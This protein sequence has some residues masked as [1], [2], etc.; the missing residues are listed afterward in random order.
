MQWQH[1]WIIFR[2]F[3]FLNLLHS[4]SLT[5]ISFPIK[6]LKTLLFLSVLLLAVNIMAESEERVQTQTYLK[7]KRRP[8]YSCPGCFRFCLRHP[9]GGQNSDDSDDSDSSS[10]DSSSSIYGIGSR[11][12]ASDSISVEAPVW[13]PGGICRRCVKKCLPKLCLKERPSY[14]HRRW[15]N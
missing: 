7:P 3:S 4:T 9:R 2:P 10:D 15:Y 13:G 1:Q 11:S 8:I 12:L 5:L 6:M 14:G